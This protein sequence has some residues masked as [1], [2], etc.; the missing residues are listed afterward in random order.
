VEG[1]RSSCGDSTEL[2]LDVLAAEQAKGYAGN[3]R[4]LSLALL[5]FTGTTPSVCCHLAG[6][7]GRPEIDTE[8]D[9]VLRHTQREVV[10][11]GRKK[12]LNASMLATA[13]PA[14][15]ATP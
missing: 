3:E 5:R 10:D 14:A 1:S 12:K 7:D 15:Y 6:H 9:P 8:R 13:V 2:V 11:G 4:R